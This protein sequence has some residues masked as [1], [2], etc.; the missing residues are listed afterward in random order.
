MRISSPHNASPP[1]LQDAC[2][3]TEALRTALSEAAG[4]IA[5]LSLPEAAQAAENLTHLRNALLP[6]PA[7]SPALRELDAAL[8]S[9]IQLLPDDLALAPAAE[10]AQTMK[11]LRR[12]LLVDRRHTEP[13]PDRQALS[14]LLCTRQ[15]QLMENKALLRTTRA[16]ITE[17]HHQLDQS[18]DPIEQELLQTHLSLLEEYHSIIQAMVEH[19]QEEIDQLL[20]ELR[21]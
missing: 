12:T 2:A 17:V 5:G 7:Y 15:M 13:E 19:L 21:G 1:S 16:G 18:V 8:L 10:F 4:R 9:V 6:P 14:L 20:T 3:Q 11:A